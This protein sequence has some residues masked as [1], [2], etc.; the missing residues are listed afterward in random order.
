MESHTLAEETLAKEAAPRQPDATRRDRD[1]AVR[2]R[3]RRALTIGAVCKQLQREFPEIS[4]S[5]IRYLEDQRLLAPRR[6]QGGYRLYSPADV[7]RLRTILRLQRDEFLPLR[8]IRHELARGR[9]AE[10]TDGS[11]NARPRSISLTDAAEPLLDGAQLAHQTG[12]EEP[13]VT[14]LEEF[15]IIGHGERGSASA[16]DDVDRE[17]VS[18]VAELRRYGVGGRNLRVLRT[19][20]EREASLLEQLLGAPLR[21]SSL[22]RRRQAI[23]SLDALAAVVSRLQH[24]LLMRDLRRLCRRSNEAA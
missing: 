22:E 2:S 9:H 5:K 15:G 6:T 14:E 23:E 18:T 3:E 19:S 10:R 8:V 21:S 16:F 11:V 7:A 1:E 20:A 4:I 24:L 17:I 13:F 12:V